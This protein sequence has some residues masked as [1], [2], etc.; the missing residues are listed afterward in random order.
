MKAWRIFCCCIW[1][2]PAC[3]YLRP[4]PFGSWSSYRLVLRVCNWRGRCCLISQ[5]HLHRPM[6]LTIKKDF[7]FQLLNVGA[8]VKISLVCQTQ[9]AGKIH[10]GLMWWRRGRDKFY[11]CEFAFACFIMHTCMCVWLR[12]SMFVLLLSKHI[13]IKLVMAA[14]VISR[15]STHKKKNP[16]CW[17]LLSHRGEY[18]YKLTKQ[19]LHNTNMA[20][21]NSTLTVHKIYKIGVVLSSSRRDFQRQEQEI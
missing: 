10:G 1:P 12:H 2:W 20:P 5:E 15:D 4:E 7:Y 6:L 19:L 17:V 9:F 8:F 16:S 21:A 14:L 13:N 11:S 3:C 18:V